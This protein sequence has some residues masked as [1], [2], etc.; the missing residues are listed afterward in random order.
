MESWDWNVVK[1]CHKIVQELYSCPWPASQEQTERGLF[2]VWQKVRLRAEDRCILRL[3]L[4]PLPCLLIRPWQV[5]LTL[6]FFFPVFHI[7]WSQ[8][9]FQNEQ[10][11]SSFS[12]YE[13]SV[14]D[15]ITVRK[16]QS[17]QQDL[18]KHGLF[19]GLEHLPATFSFIR[20]SSLLWI[21]E[22]P[23]NSNSSV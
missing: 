8:Y 22:N 2:L 1:L 3:R 10:S 9:W 21:E 20:I 14:F 5:W 7:Q 23:C 16:L 11:S 15:F 18:I 4:S 6:T 17:C 19:S 12:D 13:S